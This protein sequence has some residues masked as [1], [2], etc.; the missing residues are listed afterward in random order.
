M[1]DANLL[2]K[3]NCKKNYLWSH[4][5]QSIEKFIRKKQLLPFIKYKPVMILEGEYLY[6]NRS[7]FISFFGKKILKIAPDY[8]FINTHIDINYIPS[9]NAIFTT[10]S[11]R[12]LD[13]LL[14]SWREIKKTNIDSKLYINP[15][16]NLTE[17]TF[18]M[19]EG[20]IITFP[21]NLTF[22]YDSNPSNEL[23]T[24]S[25]NIVPSA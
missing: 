11:D 1:S 9:S 18:S 17:A 23:I 25:A 5:I 24:L 2:G 8:D 12:N 7:F 10:K 3:I 6:K 4:S 14:N 19:K 21:A 22:G 13:F 15:P 16:Y 20:D